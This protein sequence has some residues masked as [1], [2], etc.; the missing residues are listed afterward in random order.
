MRSGAWLQA[1]EWRAPFFDVGSL[2]SYLEANLAWLT[3]RSLSHWV[4]SGSQVSSGVSLERT[5]LGACATAR[6]R[7]TIER[8]V[9]WP[10]ESVEAPLADAIVIPGHIVRVGPC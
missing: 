1:F 2:T 8:C 3:Q 9:V 6:G 10:G 4:G 7:G 5:I